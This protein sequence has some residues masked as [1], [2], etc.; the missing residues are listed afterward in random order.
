[1]YR[2]LTTALVLLALAGSTARA[3]LL[4]DEQSPLR[5][6]AGFETGFV[7]VLGHTIQFGNDGTRFDY[8]ADGGQDI[9]FPFR[10]LTAELAVGRRHSVIFL[11]QPLDIR[12]EALL[13][14]D[15]IVDD[16][17]F[18]AGTPVELR[19]GFDFYR[20]SWLYDFLSQP[21]RE[22]AAGLSLQVR[23]ASISFA[24]RNGE[25]F[26]INQNVGPV[27]A[28]KLRGRLPLGRRAWLGT[29]ID[30]IYA[31]GKGFTGSTNVNR[32]FIGALLDASARAGWRFTDWLDGYV[33]I[34][35]LGGGAR[36]TQLEHKGPG[37]G[38]TDNWLGIGSVTLGFRVQ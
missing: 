5:L 12:T 22:L 17:T 36:G 6:R 21:D 11:V 31:A 35:Y 32:E 13:E 10:R 14:Q 27:P 15:L 16:L 37:D 9:L 24:A 29:E 30:G 1:M 28:I 26:R 18:T 7:G 38:Y 4:G 2:T 19:Y 20:A 8:V 25:Q 3:G 33:N 23:N 34:R